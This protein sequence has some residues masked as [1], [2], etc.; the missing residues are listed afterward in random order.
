MRATLLT[1]I[2]VAVLCAP[3]YAMTGAELLQTSRGFAEGYIFGAMEYR[4]T[5]YS[6]ADRDIQNS[7]RACIARSSINSAGLYEAVMQFLR[8]NPSSL[9]EPGVVAVI[10]TLRAM[11]PTEPPPQQ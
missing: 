6:S 1:A 3:A 11:C 4:L 2:G 8:N 9:P 5:I 10:K 7:D